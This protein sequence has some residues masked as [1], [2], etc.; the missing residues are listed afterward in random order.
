[1]TSNEYRDG[2][3]TGLTYVN[4]LLNAGTSNVRPLLAT[5]D[6][7]RYLHI[8]ERQPEPPTDKPEYLITGDGRLITPLGLQVPDQ[9]CK[10]G[11]WAKV[12]DV[13][14]NVGGYSDLRPIYIE[15]AEYNVDQDRTAYR[16]ANAYEQ[17]R[18]AKYI[19]DAVTG[20]A[21]GS[22][23]SVQSP[24]WWTPSGEP[25]SPDYIKRPTL[26]GAISGISDFTGIYY[27]QF[28]GS[29]G[30]FGNFTYAGLNYMYWGTDAD[31][32]AG[33]EILTPGVYRF[34]VYVEVNQGASVPTAGICLLSLRKKRLGGI[35]QV[36]LPE[37]SHSWNTTD[38]QQ[39]FSIVCTRR[40][41]AGDFFLA[42]V[43]ELTDG[44]INIAYGEFVGEY[45][46]P[47]PIAST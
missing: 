44:E 16:P 10:V 7:K 29:L 27:M 21:S 28:T 3:S 22:G 8:Y 38:T 9:E 34:E 47:M 20:G 46:Y 24:I 33:L 4:Q 30:N 26:T 18:L 1:M 17:I 41:N 42:R 23:G 40:F 2:R 32:N 12:Q 45:L 6:A 11:V 13:P 37:V 36:I 5:V 43:Q 14:A 25:F 15:S 31:G 19:A 35:G 39:H